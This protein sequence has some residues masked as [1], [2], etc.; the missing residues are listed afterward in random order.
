M[1][2]SGQ[3]YHTVQQ[4]VQVQNLTQKFEQISV[5]ELA[6]EETETT[7]WKLRII[8]FFGIVHRFLR[9]CSLLCVEV[10]IVIDFTFRYKVLQHVL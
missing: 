2:T 1:S 4:I 6:Q 5:N 3:L 10:S 9:L 8:I 7:I